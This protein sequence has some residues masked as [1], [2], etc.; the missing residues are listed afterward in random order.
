M[1]NCMKRG[2]VEMKGGG[3]KT[4]KILYQ[5][6]TII[7]SKLRGGRGETLASCVDP[8]FQDPAP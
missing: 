2:E 4:I 6:Y 8:G 1:Q 7:L 5:I 3:G